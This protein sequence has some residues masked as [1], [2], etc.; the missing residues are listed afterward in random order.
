MSS[1]SCCQKE[2]VAS[3]IRF[4]V[5]E[6]LRTG[7]E[8]AQEEC[9][10]ILMALLSCSRAQ[11]YLGREQAVP[12]AVQ[13]RFLEIVEKRKTRIP[14][15]YLLE[16]TDFW[17]ETLFVN[18]HCLIPRP[19]TEI[20]VEKTIAAVK[21]D[22]LIFQMGTGTPALGGESQPPKNQP[23]PLQAFSFLDIG[24]GSGAIA[25]AIL[26]EFPNVQGTLLDL[27]TEAL[28][29]A[30]KNITKYELQDR[31]ELI[32]GD[33]LESWPAGKS[34]DLIVSNPPYLN[35]NDFR[36]LQPELKFEPKQAL[37]GGQDGLSFYKKIVKGAKARLTPQGIL[38]LEV[39]KGQAPTVSK[40]LHN[41]GYDKIQIFRDYL[42]IERVVTARLP[43]HRKD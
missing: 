32:Q 14:L 21:G 30:R 15:A 10:R 6:L 3:C 24:T 25:I 26:R 22:R 7:I 12:P 4:A 29:V 31:A 18:E 36:N 2:G 41:E 42:K 43:A 38:A 9:E 35:E 17:K 33:I 20:L 16:E 37:D 5:A 23:V 28:E 19:E 39:G 40:W 8:E 11:L 1:L 34:W 13:E 27:S